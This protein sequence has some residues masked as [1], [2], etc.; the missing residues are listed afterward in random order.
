MQ[1][2]AS[3]LHQLEARYG[4]PG[5]YLVAFWGMETDFGRN[6]GDFSVVRS[7]ATLAYDGRRGA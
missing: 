3:L 6:T 5:R 1:Q 7:L 2:N 4:V